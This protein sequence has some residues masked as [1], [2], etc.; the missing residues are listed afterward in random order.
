MTVACHCGYRSKGEAWLGSWGP[1]QIHTLGPVTRSVG[2]NENSAGA[3]AGMIQQ[4]RLTTTGESYKHQSGVQQ[5][6]TEMRQGK[7][8][9]RRGKTEGRRRKRTTTYPRCCNDTRRRGTARN[10]RRGY[11][12]QKNRGRAARAIQREV[13]FHVDLPQN[14]VSSVEYIESRVQQTWKT[15][16]THMQ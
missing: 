9:R 4:G 13:E 6:E 7:Q 8:V 12:S 5:D 16:T 1:R 15:D 10:G 14:P 3:A 2:Q 11:V